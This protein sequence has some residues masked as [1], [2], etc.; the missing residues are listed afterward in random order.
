MTI[1]V[2]AP[3]TLYNLGDAVVPRSTDIVTNEQPHNNS[4]EDG[5][6]HWAQHDDAGSTVTIAI[7]TD[8]AFDGTQSASLTTG[9]G[10]YFR[11]AGGTALINDFM[12]DVT[13]GQKINF[14]CYCRRHFN[15]NQAADDSGARIYWYDSSH[16]LISFSVA[17]TYPGA[18]PGLTP[19]GCIGGS[20][21]ADQWLKSTG[22]AIAPAGAAFASA[23]IY[24]RGNTHGQIWVD[25]YTW[26]YT[27]QG[28]PDGL[29]FVATQATAAT[30]AATEPNWPLESGDTVV[31]GGVTWEG[32][33]ASRITWTAAPILESGDTEPTWPTSI[34]GAV[35]DAAGTAHAISWIA[36]DGR[37]TDPNCPQ[38]TVVAIAQ[39]KIFAADSD[40]IPFSATTN[41][42]DW[43]TANDAPATCR[44]ACRPTA[45][46]PWPRW[47]FTAPIW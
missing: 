44:S 39:S 47:A 22:S 42:L 17:N 34:G 30:S 21:P 33:F 46:S 10:S 27:H 18:A 20:S 25:N 6:T 32:E 14:S 5:L 26:D 43:T 1:P 2:W 4:F 41:P 31:D 28:L 45:R 8:Q 16:D 11:G 7:E 3:T 12:A 24:L 36:V 23:G 29:I 38:S 13:P 37:V 35:T 9:S 15:D 40:T 19:P